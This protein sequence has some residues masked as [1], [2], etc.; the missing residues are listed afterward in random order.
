MV[1]IQPCG[2][3]LTF[4][5]QQLQQTG[6]VPTSKLLQIVMTEIVQSSKQINRIGALKGKCLH[7]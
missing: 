4:N 1:Y 3:C 7:S 2:F 6:L 5:F